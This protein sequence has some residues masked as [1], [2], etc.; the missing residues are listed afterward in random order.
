M[1]VIRYVHQ[2]P[3]KAGIGSIES[4]KWSSYKYYINESN[5]M[6]EVNQILGMI[7]VDR[8]AALREFT[9]FN[10]EDTDEKFNEMGEDK[11]INESNLDAFISEYLDNKNISRAELRNPDNRGVRDELIKVLLERSN[12][13]RRGIAI[14][15]GLNRELV[16][17]VSKEP[18]P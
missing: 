12:L 15:L 11:E 4:Y 13:S 1:S 17:R 5:S 7:S 8:N 6:E 9:R 10:H 2:N 3:W 14:V 16:R 18:S